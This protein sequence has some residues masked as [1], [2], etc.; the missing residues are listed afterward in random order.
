MGCSCLDKLTFA[1]GV[2]SQSPATCRAVVCA[3]TRLRASWPFTL[4]TALVGWGGEKKKKNLT[5]PWWCLDMTGQFSSVV[6]LVSSSP[7]AVYNLHHDAGQIVLLWPVKTWGRTYQTQLWLFFFIYL[8]QLDSFI[9][10]RLTD[11]LRIMNI[12][13]CFSLSL[14]RLLNPE[15]GVT[16]AHFGWWKVATIL[17]MHKYQRFHLTPYAEIQLQLWLQSCLYCRSGVASS[18]FSLFS[19]QNSV[20]LRKVS[21][22]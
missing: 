10:P 2:L 3:L 6:T 20:K 18:P 21:G 1:T 19:F 8:W 4:L 11:G 12:Q 5:A 15:W 17:D 14:W 22:D 13:Y 9:H 16:L 7:E